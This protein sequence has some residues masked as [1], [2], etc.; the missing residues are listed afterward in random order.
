MIDLVRLQGSV[1]EMKRTVV[2]KVIWKHPWSVQRG[3]DGDDS[4]A[5]G[6]MI[7]GRCQVVGYG[8]NVYPQ[9]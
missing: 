6:E 7:H 2:G 4:V 3:I 9:G 5:W 8:T 1:G